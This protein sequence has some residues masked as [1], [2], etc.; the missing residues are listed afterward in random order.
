V[1]LIVLAAPVVPAF[2]GR[3]DP[4][5]R[6]RRALK[7]AAVVFG[8][9]IAANVIHGIDDLIAVPASAGDNAVAAAQ[10]FLPLAIAAWA[11][12]R[13]SRGTPGSAQALLIGTLVLVVGLGLT[14]TNVLVSSQ[15]ASLLPEWFSRAVVAADFGVVGP[16]ILAIIASGEL[17]AAAEPTPEPEPAEEVV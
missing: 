13:A 14:H 17:R 3:N 9:V 8:V 12:W 7:S 4:D 16:A 6:R 10:T 1:A 5:A 2:L 11:S 15:V